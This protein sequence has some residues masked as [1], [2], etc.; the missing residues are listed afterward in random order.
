MLF[1]FAVP[2]DAV[3][4]SPTPSTVRIADSSKGEV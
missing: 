4:H 2:Y 1:S 3:D